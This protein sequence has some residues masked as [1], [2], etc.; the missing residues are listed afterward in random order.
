MSDDPRIKLLMDSVLSLSETSKAAVRKMEQETQGRGEMCFSLY[1]FIVRIVSHHSALARRFANLPASFDSEESRRK[2]LDDLTQIER[3][4]ERCEDLI[5][6]EKRKDEP[7]FVQKLDGS[8]PV[9][10]V[11]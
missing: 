10:P 11:I 5:V 2:F 8:P 3:E 1:E 6:K 9:G 7:P 4:C